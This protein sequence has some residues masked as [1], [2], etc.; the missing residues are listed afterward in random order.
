VDFFKKKKKKKKEMVERKNRT[1]NNGGKW[2]GIENHTRQ[3]AMRMHACV[4]ERT[5]GSMIS[6]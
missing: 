3:N 6:F 4:S 1:G 2:R 5:S